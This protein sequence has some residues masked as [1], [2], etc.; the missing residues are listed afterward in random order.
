MD[1]VATSSLKN[2]VD[3]LTKLDENGVDYRNVGGC[4]FPYEISVAEH[5]D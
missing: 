4:D 1:L 3:I 5:Y 2:D